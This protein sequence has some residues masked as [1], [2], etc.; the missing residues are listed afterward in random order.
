MNINQFLPRLAESE[1]NR[2]TNTMRNRIAKAVAAVLLLFAG[3]FTPI[4]LSSA[5]PPKPRA[6]VVSHLS[7]RGS[8][9]V[10]MFA[11]RD[12]AEP[13]YICNITETTSSLQ[14]TLPI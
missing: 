12:A 2:C 10:E 14:L 1:N 9:V 13:I 3:L 8:P 6:Q 4:R 7:L 5:T 11:E